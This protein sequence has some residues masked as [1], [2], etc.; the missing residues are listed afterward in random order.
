VKEVPGTLR[1]GG[2]TFATTHWSVIAACTGGNGTSAE[3]AADALAQLCRDYWP[4]LYSFVRRRGFSSADAQDLVQGFF[5]YFLERKAYAKIDRQKGKFRSFMVASLKNYMADVWD[6]EHALKRGGGHE[7]VLLDEELAAVETQTMSHSAEI[8]SE[9]QEFERRWAVALVAR[10]LQNLEA[11]F[12]QGPKA[13]LFTE[14]KRFITGGIGLPSQEE[15]AE[16]LEMPI[17]TLRSHLSRMRARYRELLREE[18]ARTVS[19]NDD[20]DEELRH[21]C[22]ILAAAS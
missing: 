21:L 12:G 7:F 4:P 2:A 5:S 18:V 15:V 17:E 20:V 10:A 22:S 19:Q 13:R 14:L 11:Q 6:R 16:R 8:V 1:E 3:A 9:E